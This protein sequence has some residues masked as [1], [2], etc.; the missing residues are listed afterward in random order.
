MKIFTAAVTAAASLLLS[1]YALGGIYYTDH[2]M[3]GVTAAGMDLSGAEK[4][5]A[6]QAI[7]GRYE[8]GSITIQERGGAVETIA[9][10]DIGLKADISGFEKELEEMNAASWP[11]YYIRSEKEPLAA[12]CGIDYDDN[13]LIEA[14]KG[15]DIIAN[16]KKPEDAR[17]ELT[18][19]GY[20]IIPEDEGAMV[21]EEKAFERLEEAVACGKDEVSFEDLYLQPSV[22]AKDPAIQE[23]MAKIDR[24]QHMTIN[25]D[26]TGAQEVMDKSVI[27]RWISLDGGVSI[28][29]DKVLAYV[30]ELSY[31]YET[32]GTLR[33]FHTSEGEDI[34]VGGEGDTYGF[35]M[36]EGATADLLVELAEKGKDADAE[37]VWKVKAKTRG[38]GNG[39]IGSSYIE[40]SLSSQHLWFY[41][42]GDLVLE[43]DV[44]T[45]LPAEGRSTPAGV[46]R[47]W[48]KER[49]ATLTSQTYG[50]ESHVSYW[51]PITWTGIGLHDASWRGSFGGSIYLSNGSHGCVNLPTETA[52]ALFEADTM[53][54]PVI[55]HY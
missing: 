10:K 7:K 52:R 32:L 48:H 17:I 26:M 46:F 44:V 38:Q 42:D 25:M 54:M 30:E 39:D 9:F 3:P 55:I 18:D 1:I 8:E 16:A 31:K 45:G 24:F 19:R 20:E 28:D 21:D 15:L 35:L 50:Y 33:S 37:P 13:L 53:D 12:D 27:S 6:L 51:M 41:Q 14:F 40:V 2:V 22:R 43:S 11:E 5:E 4:E 49:D 47:I 29:R 34:S 23:D 36:D